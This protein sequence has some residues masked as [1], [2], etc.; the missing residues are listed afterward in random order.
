MLDLNSIQSPFEFMGSAICE[1]SVQNHLLH[2]GPQTSPKIE[3]QIMV[4]NVSHEVEDKKFF[5]TVALNIKINLITKDDPIEDKITF[6]LE[7]GFCASDT[8][9]ETLF[10]NMLSLNGSTIL[11]SIA[12]GK[13]E[14]ISSAIFEYGKIELPVVN[15]NQ[16]FEKE[17]SKAEKN[18]ID[19]Q[20]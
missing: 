3:M 15:M 5:G 20:E 17:A 4:S 1:M 18:N 13:I 8:I 9:D 19:K 7:G 6:G 14:S 10:S 16:Y 2:I 11:Y 12:R